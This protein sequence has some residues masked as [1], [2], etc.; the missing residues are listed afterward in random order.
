MSRRNNRG[1]E[2]EETIFVEEVPG[3][4]VGLLVLV[5]VLKLSGTVLNLEALT[6]ALNFDRLCV[7]LLIRF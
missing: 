1:T 4:L 5:L 3:M 7:A 6:P 2:E